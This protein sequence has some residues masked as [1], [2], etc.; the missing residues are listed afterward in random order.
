VV[1]GVLRGSKN[2]GQI[3]RCYEVHP[4][5]VIHWRKEFLEKGPEIFDQK[6]AFQ[7]YEKGI[8]K[9]ECLIGHK[10]V[11]IVLLKTSWPGAHPTREDRARKGA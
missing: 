8:E 9:L 11:E 6:A 4:I 7:E 5:T 1:L 10:E 3:D 2:L